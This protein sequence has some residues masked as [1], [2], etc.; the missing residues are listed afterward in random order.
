MKTERKMIRVTDGG[1]YVNCGS[2]SLYKATDPCIIIYVVESR[3][4]TLHHVS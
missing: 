1:G 2:H 3:A 4:L